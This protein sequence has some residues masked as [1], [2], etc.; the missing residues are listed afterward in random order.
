MDST[1]LGTAIFLL[2]LGTEPPSVKTYQFPNLCFLSAHHLVTVSKLRFSKLLL[3]TYIGI[4]LA[5]LTALFLR[6]HV[7][8]KPNVQYCTCLKKNRKK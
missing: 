5:F 7:R 8:L 1:V 3:F 4:F 6:C 2:A